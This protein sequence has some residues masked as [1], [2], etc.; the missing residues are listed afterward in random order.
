MFKAEWMKLYKRKSVK[1]LLAIYGALV[2]AM[3]LIY[4]LGEQ[5]LGLS[6]Y[7]ESQFITSSL[8]TVMT[9]ILPFIALYVS[10]ASFGLEFSKGTFKNMLLMPVSKSSL[11]IN[12]L[13]AVI[14][15]LGGM[16]IMQLVYSL[17]F[18]L[19]LDG[20]FTM[21]ILMGVLGEYLGA[22]LILGLIAGAGA[23]MAMFITS[24]GLAVFIGY[25]IY[26]GI[27]ILNLYLPVIKPVSLTNIMSTYNHLLSGGF[28]I[29][30]LSVIA[31]YIIIL[32]TGLMLFE[33]KEEDTCLYE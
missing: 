2:V 7:T 26:M 27:G 9:F 15:L 13:M 29:Q 30:L 33:Q 8:G 17:A 12:K 20:G 28:G 21:T 18:S 10:T 3:S 32:T 19:I 25:L 6:L 31:Y 24:T 22:F 23:L 14:S 11:Y 1:V 16:L 5:K 4:V